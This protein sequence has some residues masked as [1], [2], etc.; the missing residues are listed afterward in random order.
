MPFYLTLAGGVTTHW[1][2]SSIISAEERKRLV[3]DGI[4]TSN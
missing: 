1:F 3:V 2:T 4:Y